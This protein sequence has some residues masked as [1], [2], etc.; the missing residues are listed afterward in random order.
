[1]KKLAHPELLTV[2]IE[3]LVYGGQGIGTLPDGRKIFVWN[4][5]PGETVAVRMGRSKKSYA[6]GIAVQIENAAPERVTPVDPAY[7][8]TSPWQIMTI[9]CENEWKQAI[10]AET[11]AREKVN[12]PK[13]LPITTF[14]QYGY[15]NKMEYSFWGDDEHGLCLALFNRGSHQKVMVDGS[16]ISMPAL[17]E[18]ARAIR[19]YLRKLE[20]RAGDLKS[21]IVRAS[22]SG[23]VVASLYCKTEIDIDVS[24]LIGAIQ[25][26][27]VW[28]SDPRSPAS[29][30]TRLLS[31]AGDAVLHDQL[32]GVE[33]AY[34][35]DSFFQVNIPVYEA[36]LEK[37][38]K[39]TAGV[40]R[41][42]DMYSGVGTI[43]L[44]CDANE[45]VLVEID[46]DNVA[47][48]K[49]NV[50]ASGK[51]AQVIQASTEKA[52]EYISDDPVI[53]DPPRAGLHPKLV[54]RVLDVL[55]SKILYLSCNPVTQARDMAR[56]QSAYS[57]VD[58]QLFNFFPRTPHIE[59]LLVLERSD[60]IKQ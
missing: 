38:K 20:V 40:P 15:R 49:Q 16:A 8:A 46:A 2:Q 56:L 28:Y 29:V 53:F 12:I 58:A 5:L 36:V 6:E 33:Y 45:V 44:S 22:Q 9:E 26:I 54:D 35:A 1:M 51:N 18:G 32:L 52:L 3:K 55:P 31:E 41:L 48:A 43:G 59:S 24:P 10:V 37:I 34:S 23:S 17:D 21:V 39:A 50:V 30:Q 27:R 60:T 47:A 4:A 57:V 7:L 14:V 11:F 42:I 25:G 19:D 13:E